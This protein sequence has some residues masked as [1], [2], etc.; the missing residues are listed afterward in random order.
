MSKSHRLRMLVLA[1]MFASMGVILKHF[2]LTTYEFRFSFYDLPLFLGGMFLGPVFGL[3][4]GFV[5]DWVYVLT[6]PWA[7]SFNFFTLS[8]MTWGLMGGLFFYLPKH[9][10]IKKLT[11]VVIF[12]SLIAFSF[13]T[14]QL[15]I[16]QNTGMFAALPFRITAMIL[17]WPIQVYALNMIYNRIMQASTLTLSNDQY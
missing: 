11:F 7:F 13:N 2:A 6:S 9:L 15:Y 16:M 12:T 3:V 5:V 4:I 14:W 17:K 1:G 10:S 8:A